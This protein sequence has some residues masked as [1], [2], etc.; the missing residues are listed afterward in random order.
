MKSE[1]IMKASRRFLRINPVHFPPDLRR[2][3]AHTG[4]VKD[5][6]GSQLMLLLPCI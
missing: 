1:A 5:L 3:L 4:E 6:D 2:R